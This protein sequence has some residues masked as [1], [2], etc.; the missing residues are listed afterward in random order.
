MLVI[1]KDDVVTPPNIVV[2]AAEATFA[3]LQA[4]IVDDDHLLHR[5]YMSLEWESLLRLE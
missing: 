4:R 3:H 5:T 1:G 2:P